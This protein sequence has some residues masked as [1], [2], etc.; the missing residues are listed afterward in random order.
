ME[1]QYAQVIV[2][3][4]MRSFILPRLEF[5]QASALSKTSGGLVTI[6]RLPHSNSPNLLNILDLI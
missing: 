5:N 1:L 4:L 2:P 3:R 6:G